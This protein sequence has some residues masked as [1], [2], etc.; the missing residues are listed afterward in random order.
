MSTFLYYKTG[1]IRKEFYYYGEPVIQILDAVK[2]IS[3]MCFTQQKTCYE[4]PS[5]EEINIGIENTMETPCDHQQNLLCKKE[6]KD[7]VEGRDTV[8]WTVSEKKA[9][10]KTVSVIWVDSD[11]NIP[12]K[13]EFDNGTRM[14][15]KWIK[16]ET[17]NE[18][19]TEKWSQSVY[20]PNGSEQHSFQWFDKELKISIREVFPDGRK[21]ELN[22]IKLDKLPDSLFTL[23]AGFSQIIQKPA[24]PKL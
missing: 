5:L 17:I 14:E 16:E 9:P 13:Q 22:H 7:K 2:H 20:Y 15:L 12:V 3:L 10:K 1:R 4:T 23:P 24:A 8:K 11:L 18:R 6:G 21:Q 19:L